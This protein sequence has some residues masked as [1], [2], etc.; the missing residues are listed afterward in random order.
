M[1]ARSIA[2]GPKLSWK[3]RIRV[4]SIKALRFLT[5]ACMA[6]FALSASDPGVFAATFTATC[7][8]PIYLSAVG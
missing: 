5:I 2:E 8:S 7:L 4:Y 6:W 1:R 3:H